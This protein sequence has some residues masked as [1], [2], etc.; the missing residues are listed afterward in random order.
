MNRILL[1]VGVCLGVSASAA[2]GQVVAE[3][4]PAG[5]PDTV[6]WTQGGT[7]TEQYPAT[8]GPL[9][10]DPD[11]PAYDAWQI[12]TSG[13]EIS[14]TWALTDEQKTEAFAT[15]WTLTGTWR[16]ESSVNNFSGSNF[17]GMRLDEG[18]YQ[19]R[20]GYGD[21]EDDRAGQ[22]VI[23]GWP[24]TSIVVPLGGDGYH[25]LTFV[26][27]PA[28]GK[29]DFYVGSTLT[30]EDLEPLGAGDIGETRIIFGGAATGNDGAGVTDYSLVR[31]EIGMHIPQPD[32]C[33]PG[34][35][36]GDG[37][38][39][40]DDLSLLLAHWGGTVDCTKGE[41]S[42][43]PPVN[44]DD[45]SLLLAHWTGSLAVPEPA[46]LGLLAV[47]GLVLLQRRYRRRTER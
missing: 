13:G 9:T 15:G 47:S 42:G 40:D 3:Y 14:Y 19:V 24:G 37:D 8:E 16:M 23:A 12:A 41:F 46:T 1:V 11:F 31:F 36:D 29:A 20:M 35:A 4:V 17:V 10:P 32:T 28:D 45:L 7:I 2:W 5:D 44:D 6:G 22:L 25:T 30:N 18:W 21:T 26:Y 39:D 38:V 34:D 43:V 27:D 33:S